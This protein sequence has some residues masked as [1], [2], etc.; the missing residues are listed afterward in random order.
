[1]FCAVEQLAQLL[2][3]AAE[4]GN[5][6]LAACAAQ[7]G[8]IVLRGELVAA[9]FQL[10]ANGRAQARQQRRDEQR[11]ADRQ[12]HARAQRRIEHAAAGRIAD[13]DEGELAALAQQQATFDGAAP[14]QAADPEQQGHDNALDQHQPEDEGGQPQRRVE[15]LAG[16]DASSRPS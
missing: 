9:R 14:R 8:M 2:A 16:V 1:M 11:Q 4:A 5:D 3:D 7:G 13:D 12:H 6:D 15:D 10:V